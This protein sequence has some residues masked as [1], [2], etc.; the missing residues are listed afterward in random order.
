MAADFFED[1]DKR[2]ETLDVSISLGQ[3]PCRKNI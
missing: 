2:Y 1:R 3:Q